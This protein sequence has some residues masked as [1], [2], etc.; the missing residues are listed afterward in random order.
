MKIVVDTNVTVSG[1]LWGGPP[2]QILKWARDKTIRIL[3]CDK[4]LDRSE[5]FFDLPSS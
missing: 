1:L 4:M 5:G 3:A 2:N